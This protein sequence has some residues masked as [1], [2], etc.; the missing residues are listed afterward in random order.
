ME[1]KDKMNKEI[2]DLMDWLDRYLTNRLMDDLAPDI[3]KI[4]IEHLGKRPIHLRV[5]REE[6][7]RIILKLAVTLDRSDDPPVIEFGSITE[8]IE[9]EVEWIGGADFIDPFDVEIMEE[10]KRE[11]NQGIEKIS[12]FLLNKR[13]MK[14]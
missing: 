12:G 3:T 1:M 14:E 7:N 11:L 8:L 13:V 10:L 9:N 6:N 2:I 5:D 4:F